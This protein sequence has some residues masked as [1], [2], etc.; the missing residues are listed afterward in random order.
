LPIPASLPPIA[1]GGQGQAVASLICGILSFNCVGVL[2]VP[3]ILLGHISLSKIKR[4]LMPISARGL[5]LSGLILGYVNMAI[6]AAV[7]LLIFAFM[8][9]LPG[10]EDRQVSNQIS[11]FK[12]VLDQLNYDF[13]APQESK[14][15]AACQNNLKQMGLVFKMFAN[16]HKGQKY[17]KISDKP[18]QLMAAKDEI[19]PEYLRAC[20]KSAFWFSEG[21][22]GDS[23]SLS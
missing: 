16:E 22:I 10:L 14:R 6:F 5:A 12:N 8:L 9:M 21:P 11:V 19:Y 17:P 1:S 18:G 4:G 23:S 2:A 13:G 20:F 3:A 15:I 7:V